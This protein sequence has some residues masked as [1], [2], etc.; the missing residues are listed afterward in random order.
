MHDKRIS[1]DYGRTPDTD[2]DKSKLEV[3]RE[4]IN[5]SDKSPT[6]PPMIATP[7]IVPLI[8]THDSFNTPKH[9]TAIEP[10]ATMNPG[11]PM[12]PEILLNPVT[13]DVGIVDESVPE[14]SQQI[15]ASRSR[16]E[17]RNKVPIR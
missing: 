14:L 13:K 9:D 17:T 4:L 2:K 15:I 6:I 5:G 3:E 7:E 10:D 12:E 16:R 8:P 1:L 11:S